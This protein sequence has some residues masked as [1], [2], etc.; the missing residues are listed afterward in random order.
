VARARATDRLL[1]LY[2]DVDY[3]TE[4]VIDIAREHAVLLGLPFSPRPYDTLLPPIVRA[5]WILTH[6]E[7]DAVLAEPH[8]GL[9][10]S[11]S[12]GPALPDHVFVNLTR[13]GV[14]KGSAV[15]AIAAEYGVA[16]GEVMFVGDGFNDTPALRIVG[17]PVAMAD[18]EPTALA[19][20]NHVVGSV[21]QDGVAEAIARA[22][23]TLEEQPGAP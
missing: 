14:D 21:E 22:L 8:P 2:N 12:L 16:L 18:A 3:V 5:Q 6:D 13:T 9:E 20:A 19:L 10:V 1:E 15:R 4:S 7:L 11:P 17:W 23:A